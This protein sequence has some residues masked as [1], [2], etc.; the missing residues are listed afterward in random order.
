M[1]RSNSFVPTKEQRAIIETMAAYGMPHEKI[2]LA[3]QNPGTK[4]PIT[5]KTL[6]KA[7]DYELT[8]GQAKAHAAVADTLFKL[9]TGG[10]DWTKADVQA[11]KWYTQ[12]QMG[13]RPPAHEVK[14]E[15]SY[16]DMS[17]LADEQIRQLEAILIAAGI[18]TTGSVGPAP[19]REA[20]TRH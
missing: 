7:C 17:K 3:I 16:L 1:A 14:H 6:R 12:S 18:D 15:I 10:G 2:A 9:A 5:A 11:L 19:S 4:R 13:F 8:V 20:E